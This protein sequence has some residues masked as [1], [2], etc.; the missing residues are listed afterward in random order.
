MKGNIFYLYFIATTPYIEKAV[1][2]HNDYIEAKWSWRKL[3]REY[4]D[5]IFNIYAIHATEI[6]IIK[7]E[8]P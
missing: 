3:N 1:T 2:I 8:I 7:E 5:I 6:I 4:E